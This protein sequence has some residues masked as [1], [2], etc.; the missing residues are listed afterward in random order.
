MRQSK[1]NIALTGAIPVLLVLAI[2]VWSAG[3]QEGCQK[4]DRGPDSPLMTQAAISAGKGRSA[5]TSLR[6]RSLTWCTRAGDRSSMKI[7]LTW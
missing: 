3:S 1:A 6:W 5:F 4:I 2:V 7:A